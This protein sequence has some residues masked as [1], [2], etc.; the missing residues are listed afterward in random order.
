MKKRGVFATFFNMF[1]IASRCF[2]T[3][4]GRFPQFLSKNLFVFRPAFNVLNLINNAGTENP[5]YL[6]WR[7]TGRQFPSVRKRRALLPRSGMDGTRF[8]PRPVWAIGAPY[9]RPAA[10]AR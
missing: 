10:P 8:G 5:N 1:F 4:T 7:N 9:N 6:D 2:L 3:E